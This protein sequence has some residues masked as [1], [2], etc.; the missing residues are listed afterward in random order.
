MIASPPIELV[1]MDSYYDRSM[2]HATYFWVLLNMGMGAFLKCG[3]G[4]KAEMGGSALV[5]AYCNFAV[6]ITNAIPVFKATLT[7][8]KKT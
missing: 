3:Y 8:A 2:T 6:A 1:Y 5:V 4:S 7:L